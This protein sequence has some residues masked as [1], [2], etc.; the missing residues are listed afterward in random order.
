MAARLFLDFDGTLT[1]KDVGNE[2]FR[3]FGGSRC[4]LL[5]KD[6][7]AGRISAQACF[8]GEAE[9]MG[10]F[11]SAN[12]EQFLGTIDLRAGLADLLDLCRKSEIDV[13]VLSDGLDY[14]IRTILCRAGVTSVPFYANMFLLPG[15][16]G[17][18]GMARVEFPFENAECDRC[19]CCKRNVMLTLAADHDVIVYVGDGFSDKCPVQYADIVFARG[20]LQTFCREENISYFPFQ[21]LDDVRER[22]ERLLG[23]R[24]LRRRHRADTRRRALYAAEA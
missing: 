3:A 22:L 16:A 9:A 11:D 1:T 24:K 14:Y 8:R 6:Y 7:R 10:G 4:D 21:T 19:G 13:C 20:E 23:R 12:A 17:Q 15:S 5:V 2:F 18:N